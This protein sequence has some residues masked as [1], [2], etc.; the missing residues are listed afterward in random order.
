MTDDDTRLSAI[1]DDLGV[2]LSRLTLWAMGAVLAV[3]SFVAGPY[4]GVSVVANDSLAPDTASTLGGVVAVATVLAGL[5]ASFAL[6][7]VAWGLAE[8]KRWAWLSTL[9]LGAVTT[10]SCCLPVSLLFLWAMLNNRTRGLFLPRPVDPTVENGYQ[11][12]EGASSRDRVR[13]Q[14]GERA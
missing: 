9:F 8:G 10:L 1:E 3:G 7:A 5:G 13:V 4:L 6:F 11:I 12:Q 2:Q 14:G